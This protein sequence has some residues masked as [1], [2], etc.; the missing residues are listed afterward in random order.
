MIILFVTIQI[1][2]NKVTTATTTMVTTSTITETTQTGEE[3]AMIQS[4]LMHWQ[5]LS[6]IGIFDDKKNGKLEA[7]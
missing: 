4:Q 7:K 6:D 5:N 2:T 1:K 3:E